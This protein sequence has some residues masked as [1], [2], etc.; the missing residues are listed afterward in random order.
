MRVRDGLIMSAIL[1]LLGGVYLLNGPKPRTEQKNVLFM[2][3]PEARAEVGYLGPELNLTTLDGQKVSLSQFRGKP[4]VINFWTTWCGYCRSEMPSFQEVYEKYGEQVN[5]LLVNVT[6]QDDEH[7]VID[8][9]KENTFSFPVFL[10]K[11]GKGSR[12]YGVNGLPVTFIL[13]QE[14]KIESKNVGAMEV[15]ELHVIIKKALNKK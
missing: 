6:V 3:K 13:S 10:D 8:Y 1:V 2:Q 7:K 4:T 12:D 15:E 14:G 5:F 9:M 11:D